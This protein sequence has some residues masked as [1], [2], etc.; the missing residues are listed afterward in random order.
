MGCADKRRTAELQCWSALPF[1]VAG[2]LL[3]AVRCK[4]C[5]GLLSPGTSILLAQAQPASTGALGAGCIAEICAA[6]AIL[7]M[8]PCL[9]C[10]KNV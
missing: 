7:Q 5:S 6:R 4:L 3:G 9:E 1:S 8:V 2:L 10:L